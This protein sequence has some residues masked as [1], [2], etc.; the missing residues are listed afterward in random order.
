[1]LSAEELCLLERS[2]CAAEA[3]DPCS[4]VTPPAWGEA[5]P[6]VAPHTPWGLLESPHTTPAHHSLMG[7]LSAV[8][9]PCTERHVAV[10]LGRERG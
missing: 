4:S 9:N 6:R 3:E 1:M 2:L 8:D 10:C 5:V 7:R